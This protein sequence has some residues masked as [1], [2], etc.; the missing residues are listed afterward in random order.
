MDV[1][2]TLHKGVEDL[3]ARQICGVAANRIGNAPRCAQAYGIGVAGRD[4]RRRGHLRSRCW[5]QEFRSQ[6]QY[7]N[8]GEWKTPGHRTS[9][10]LSGTGIACLVN[11]GSA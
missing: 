9:Q 11:F 6:E 10:I 1:W 7:D 5:T 4:W 3:Q 8:K 2:K